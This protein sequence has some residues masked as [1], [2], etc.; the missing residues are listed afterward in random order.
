MPTTPEKARS[1]HWA[2]FEYPQFRIAWVSDQ[3]KKLNPDEPEPLTTNSLR[4]LL[5][6]S[7]ATLPIAKENPD[8][9]VGILQ[10]QMVDYLAKRII[11]PQVY[12]D[13]QFGSDADRKEFIQKFELLEHQNLP[14]PQ[15]HLER[16]PKIQP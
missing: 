16:L 11:I 5:M 2:Q 14:Y 1:V 6:I 3:L 15:L 9:Y 12:R 13:I 10:Q 8:P 4:N 7:S